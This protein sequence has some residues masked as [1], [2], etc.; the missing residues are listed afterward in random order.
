VIE[1]MG[2][3]EGRVQKLALL[4]VVMNLRLY[5]RQYQFHKKVSAACISAV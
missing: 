5:R 4:N 2:V 3:P 1:W